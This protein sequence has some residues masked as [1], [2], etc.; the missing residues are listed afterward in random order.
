MLKL[1]LGIG[2][3]I[4]LAPKAYRLYTTIVPRYTIEKLSATGEWVKMLDEDG[5]L[6]AEYQM[7]QLKKRLPDDTFQIVPYHR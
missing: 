4:W 3:G 5:K 7:R 2:A 1:L 6:M